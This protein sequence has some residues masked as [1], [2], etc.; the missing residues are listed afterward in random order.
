MRRRDLLASGVALAGTVAARS[1]LAQPP[2]P[3]RAA[4]VI[5][6][7]KAGTLPVLSGA[8][9]GA[10]TVA[11]WLGSEGFE[12]KL[13]VDDAR[14]VKANDL[15]DAISDL[16]GRGTLDQLVVYF[17]GHGY[18][19]AFSEYWMLSNAPQNPNEAIS[20]VESVILAKESAIPSVV[21]ISDA[22][23]STPES[24]GTSRVRGSLIFPNSGISQNV[25][26]DVDQFLAAL[27]GNAAAEVPV[28]QS[29]PT[30]EGIY[31][32]SLLSAF[33]KP[34][35]AIV[36][37]VNGVRV[38]P[39]RL[40]KT[41]LES[42]VLKRAEARSIKLHQ[43]PDAQ[44]VSP[45]T[46]YIARALDQPNAGPQVLPLTPSIRDV[47]AE[48]LQ[49]AG[50]GDLISSRPTVASDSEQTTVANYTKTRDAVRQAR[51]AAYGSLASAI[52]PDRML[53]Q[54]IISGSLVAEAATSPN[55]SVEWQTLGAGASKVQVNLR[56]APAASIAIRFSD[57]A[58][59]V[60]AAL[61]GF[62]C[63]IAVDA[64]GVTSASYVRIDGGFD[65]RTENLHAAVTAAAQFGV[66]RIDGERE[67]IA[68]KARD[69]GD[70]IRI[71]KSADPT[72]GL[73]A[74]Y[75]YA[76]ADL[77]DEIRSVDNFMRS[78]LQ[79]SLFDVAMLGRKLSGSRTRDAGPVFPFCPMLA[80]GWELLRVLQVPVS[81]E[82]DAARYHLRNALWTTFDPEGMSIV[83]SALRSGRLL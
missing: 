60:I 52:V 69:F 6:V 81:P 2:A 77:I 41:Y 64:I 37:M 38:V 13:F 23:R 76:Q 9:S 25:R 8:A 56:G 24:I 28:S 40:L 11:H 12:V 15:F 83:L 29:V 44:V 49:R 14:P 79:V 59:T 48:D 33:E 78:D 53:A 1:V 61:P 75:A 51:R 45:E 26:A 32:S 21:F 34:P 58:G 50:A 19:N 54:F 73:Y 17:S 62:I 16:V 18:L 42:D 5:G 71:G 36:R 46:T 10:R 82:V 43:R 57:G 20:L 31:T 68:R 72:L 63:S 70:Q 80:Q 7:N 22:C 27:P 74:A 47:A 66:F 39:N 35:E 67:T 55:A 4:V 3:V 65:E 30:F